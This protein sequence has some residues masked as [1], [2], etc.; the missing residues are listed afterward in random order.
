MGSRRLERHAAEERTFVPVYF[1]R[2][3]L[4]CVSSARVRDRPTGRTSA[5]H[6]G[7]RRVMKGGQARSGRRSRDRVNRDGDLDGRLAG[8]VKWHPGEP[9]LDDTA[10]VLTSQRRPNVV[11]YAE[12]C[13]N[14]SPI[15]TEA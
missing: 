10:R 15:T 5:S 11:L 13:F 1:R 2:E 12:L 14:G 8:S 3:V 9:H 4:G 6:R 7:L